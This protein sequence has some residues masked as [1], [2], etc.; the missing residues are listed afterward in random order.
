LGEL[1]DAFTQMEGN[2]EDLI[3]GIRS[4]S[5]RIVALA[6]ELSQA[7]AEVGQSS[8]YVA[9]AMNDLAQGATETASTVGRT[10]QEAQ[11]VTGQVAQTLAAANKAEL[12]SNESGQAVASGREAL[13]SLV[14]RI[15]A[16]AAKGEQS[17]A[18]TASL[19]QSSEEIGQITQIISSIAEETN[20]LALNAAIEAAR[21]GEHG[22]GFAVVAEEVRKLAEQS[23]QAVRRIGGLIENIQ[24]ETDSLVAAM[25]EDA[26]EIRG[27]VA[28][29]EGARGA[30]GAILKSSGA[31]DG[32]VAGI[33]QAATT[34]ERSSQVMAKAMEEISS[35]TQETAASSEEVGANAQEQASAVQQ[36]NRLANELTGLA[37]ELLDRVGQ[38]KLAT[39]LQGNAGEGKRS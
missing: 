18:A 30:F 27:G 21:A 25:E 3:G 37:R 14:G 6:G 22:R 23:K 36:I 15:N 16:I 5:T 2:L 13:E 33:L 28:A 7:S 32:E 20:L 38:F 9:R 10:V 35:V 19:R 39:D 11:N 31:I 12:A 24:D 8:E 17:L 4:A 34:L 26:A 1:S 29:V